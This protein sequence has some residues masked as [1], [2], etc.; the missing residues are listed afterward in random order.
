MELNTLEET[1]F[2]DIVNVELD[3]P[4]TATLTY[5]TDNFPLVVV[6][7]I[8]PQGYFRM[9]YSNAP[10][11]EG[12]RAVGPDGS[13][14]REFSGDQMFGG[15]PVLERLA[16]D[17]QLVDLQ[18][19][20]EPLPAQQHPNRHL[21][22]QCFSWGR[23]TKVNWCS[24]IIKPLSLSLSSIRPNSVYLVSMI[25]SHQERRLHRTLS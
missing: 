2:Q 12:K 17:R 19:H 22:P 5:L 6:P 16:R 23:E 3:V 4:I 25:S 18:V 20:P 1:F 21:M 24:R 8:A 9:R 11:Y 10:S 14:W 13:T 7:E 15:H